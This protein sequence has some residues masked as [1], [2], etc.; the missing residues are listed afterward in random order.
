LVPR[1]AVGA[2]GV[3]PMETKVAAVTVSATGLA[4]TARKAAVI[5]VEPTE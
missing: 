5:V 1:A 3:M 2:A 4:L